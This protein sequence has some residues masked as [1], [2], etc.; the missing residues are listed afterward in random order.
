MIKQEGWVMIKHLYEQGMK[1]TE[2]A[3]LLGMTR[4]T[5]SNNLKKKNTPKYVRTL[6]RPSIIE[7]YK[8]YME[9]RL[10]QYNLTGKKIYEEIQK[11][12]YTGGYGMVNI[13]TRNIKKD[14]KSKAFLRFETMPGE[15]SQVDWGYLGKIYDKEQRRWINLNCFL[16]ILGYSRTLYIEVFEKADT[17]SFLKGHNC[18]FVYFGGYT[19][20]ILYDN[21]KSVVIKRALRAKDSEFNKRFMDFAGY[22]GF[23]PILCRPY[24]PNTKGKVEN[25]VNFV[26]QNFFNGE[27]FSSL[28]QVNEKA[29]EWLEKINNRLHATT[30]EQPLVRLKREGLI[31]L[32]NKNIY[33]TTEIKYRKVF[34]DC[35]FCFEG[36]RYSVPFK[37][38]NKEV[39]IKQI[40]ENI[41]ILY[42]NLEIALHQIQPK[43][44]GKY[45]TVDD[46]FSGLKE[47]RCS[48]RLDRP[49]KKSLKEEKKM[50]I[51]TSDKTLPIVVPRSL[52]I[53]EELICNN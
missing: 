40:D 24:K 16:M 37:Y 18:A 28:N 47:L 29:R 6:N 7:K 50:S 17:L 23:S 27:L 8:E 25:S 15:Q 20:E 43:A 12:G 31:S 30:K 52:S 32:Q 4:K 2:I 45:I 35:H 22:Y 44:Q 39:A 41:H 19:R 5:V 26:K 1:K 33:D 11:Q 14:L 42:K 9:Q 10:K 49:L 3:K 51:I 38:A 13:Y 21:L 53:Y 48:H 36:N 34:S 46:H